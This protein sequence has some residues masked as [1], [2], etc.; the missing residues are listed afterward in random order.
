MNVRLSRYF[1]LA[2]V[3]C[4]HWTWLCFILLG[5]K[6]FVSCLL[7]FLYQSFVASNFIQ[8]FWFLFSILWSIRKGIFKAF[9]SAHR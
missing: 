3:H 1:Y 9:K 5:L 2:C 4:S 8:N 6:H 7:D